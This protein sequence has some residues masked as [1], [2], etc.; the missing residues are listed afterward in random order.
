M[1]F[2]V[3]GM[4]LN[5]WSLGN[6]D[7]D[8]FE[9]VKGY[10][11]QY[12]KKNDFDNKQNLRDVKK[13]PPL[14]SPKQAFCMLL[15]HSLVFK[16]SYLFVRIS[17]FYS[18]CSFTFP[19]N[20]NRLF[21]RALLLLLHASLRFHSRPLHLFNTKVHIYFFSLYLLKIHSST[22]PMNERSAILKALP[23]FSFIA[24]D[25]NNLLVSIRDHGV[26]FL[27]YGSFLHVYL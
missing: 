16:I 22:V 26:K 24:T 11:K 15:H 13:S 10:W 9:E 12:E 21:S 4:N 18:V 19:S 23:S 27:K 3:E 17:Y 7:S 25:V 20:R 14:N 1:T 5:F 6:F 2:C 8:R